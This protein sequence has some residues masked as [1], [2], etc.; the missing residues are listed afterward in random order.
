VDEYAGEGGCIPGLLTMLHHFITPT[1]SLLSRPDGLRN[2]PGTVDDF[3][4]LN[5][6]F[7]QRAPLH[8]LQVR[9]RLEINSYFVP[10]S[11]IRCGNLCSLPV[12]I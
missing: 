4:R 10:Y 1:Y 9:A 11:C 5:A 6:R 2:H 8:Y 12:R 3:F 7:M